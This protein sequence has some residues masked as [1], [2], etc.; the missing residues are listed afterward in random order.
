MSF[1]RRNCSV[2]SQIIY[3]FA[4]KKFKAKE[5]VRFPVIHQSL[6]KHQEQYL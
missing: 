6:Q 1:V 5:N 3:L 2:L 4:M